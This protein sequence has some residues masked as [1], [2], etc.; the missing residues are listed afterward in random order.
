VDVAQGAEAVERFS[1][2]GPIAV[3]SPNEQLGAHDLHVWTRVD[4]IWRVP[5]VIGVPLEGAAMDQG[6][7]TPQG[8]VD[9]EVIRLEDGAIRPFQVSVLQEDLDDLRRRLAATRFPE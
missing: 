2:I 9:D 1:L 6:S 3:R 8:T 5:A 4:C 7:K